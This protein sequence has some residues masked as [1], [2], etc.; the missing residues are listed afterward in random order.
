MMRREG[1]LKGRRE[2]GR[3]EGRRMEGWYLKLPVR[4]EAPGLSKV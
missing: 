2:E 3:R 1:G 4:S